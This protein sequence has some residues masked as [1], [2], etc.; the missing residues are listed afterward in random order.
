MVAEARVRARVDRLSVP[1]TPVNLED[2]PTESSTQPIKIVEGENRPAT[3]PPLPDENLV[4]VVPEIDEYAGETE[5]MP[6]TDVVERHSLSEDIAE[7]RRIIFA[8]IP[9]LFSNDK[10]QIA[11]A[12]AELMG[13]EIDIHSNDKDRHPYVLGKHIA[14][15]GFGAVFEAIDPTTHKAVIVKFS[16][17]F[18]RSQLIENKKDLVKTQYLDVAISRMC[19]TEMVSSKRVSQ[20]MK[21]EGGKPPFPI[22]YDGLLMPHP[23]FK[24]SEPGEVDKRIAVMVMEEISGQSLSSILE[25]PQQQYSPEVI[26]A[27]VQELITAVRLMHDKQVLHLDLKPQNIMIT[28]DN[29]AVIIDLGTSVL[30]DK[31]AE[32]NT[33]KAH[34]WVKPVGNP[35]TKNYVQGYERLTRTPER[36]V[37][38]LGI[39][40]YDMIYGM[41][42][43]KTFRAVRFNTLPEALKKL[44]AIADKM[45]NPTPEERLTL[46]QAESELKNI[47]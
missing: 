41:E 20:G 15:G 10:A 44:S 25:N 23:D 30:Q 39:T 34:N 43:S 45:T 21:R 37:Y 2:A 1:V 16:R 19:I 46:E 3:L 11:A 27:V 4:N 28:K 31:L 35:S 22:Y 5:T 7:Q 38:A 13:L 17:P 47:K 12:E 18:D 14:T 29:H 8:Q 42:S 40:I 26:L 32:D 24:P 9:E 6:V 36:D 33:R